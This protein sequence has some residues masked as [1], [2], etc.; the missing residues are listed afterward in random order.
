[1]S[2]DNES[3][4]GGSPAKT[5]KKAVVFTEREE[6]VLKVAWRCL[7]S[8]PPEL[9]KAAG[10]NTQKTC[11]NMWSGLK[12]KLLTDVDGNALPTAPAKKRAKK[13]VDDDEDD[14]DEGRS[15]AKKTKPSPCQEGPGQGRGVGRRV[16]CL[17]KPKLVQRNAS[18][19][20]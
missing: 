6:M 15:I 14:E 3:T 10:F 12:K 19:A 9:T 16:G 1:M 4:K 7:K 2:S 17:F 11:S 8:G 20:S 5:E 18:H 13:D